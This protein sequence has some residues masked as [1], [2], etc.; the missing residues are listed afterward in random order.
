MTRHGF[1]KEIELAKAF[2]NDE[3]TLNQI[4]LVTNQGAGNNTAYRL[5]ARACK[6]ICPRNGK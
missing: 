5:I 2:L 3:V 4:I 6:E 1:E